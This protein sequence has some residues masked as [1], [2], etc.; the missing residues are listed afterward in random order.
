MAYVVTARV[1]RGGKR[2]Q[3]RKFST[4]AKA[5]KFADDTNKHRPGAN[6]RV[7]KLC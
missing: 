6:A 2:I 7:K 5:Q 3:S 1:S 4:K